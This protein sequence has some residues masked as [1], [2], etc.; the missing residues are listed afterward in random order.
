MMTVL[1]LMEIYQIKH[2]KA[3]SLD[4]LIEIIE[5]SGINVLLNRKQLALE[6]LR[7]C[8]ARAAR[9]NETETFKTFGINFFML[10]K[11]YI[12]R[13]LVLMAQEYNALDSY[14]MERTEK[15]D[16]KHNE[17]ID[18]TRTDNLTH[19]RTDDLTHERTDDL[20][21]R[22]H[23]EYTDEHYVSAENES[24]VMLRTRDTHSET[25]GDEDGI[26]NTGTQTHTDS[27]TQTLTDTGTQKNDGDN[28]ITHDD[29]IK[30]GE[31][32]Y[33]ISPNVEFFNALKR[34][35]FNIYTEIASKF[36]DTMCLCVF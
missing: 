3:T 14:S 23:E 32:G 36:S 35:E 5:E 29:T 31:H 21:E 2:N 8:G 11:D 4:Y 12:D 17:K 33:K 24:G 7:Q 18:E 27:G 26:F 19:E 25:D 10:Q 16:R 28:Q 20:A 9:Y 15:I 13:T 34:N 6:I 22:K 1:D 30:I